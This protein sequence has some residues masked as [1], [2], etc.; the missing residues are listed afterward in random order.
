VDDTNADSNVCVG[1]QQGS[2]GPG[3]FDPTYAT[4]S[5]FFSRMH[6]L[7]EDG[8]SIHGGTQIW[9][10]CN[11]HGLLDDTVLDVPEGSVAIKVQD[12]NRDGSP[13]GMRV[14][15]KHQAGFDPAHGDYA[16]E[17]RAADGTDPTD[18]GPSFCFGCHQ[19][20]A[21]TGYLAGTSIIN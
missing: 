6:S 20:Y 2:A 7:S 9:Y 18:G 4:S 16:Y 5:A 19:G 21:Q 15:I 3:A 12:Q 1:T 17:A 13:D 11:L 10:S 8:T 14:M